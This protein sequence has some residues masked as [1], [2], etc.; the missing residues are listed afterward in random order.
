MSQ[1][2]WKITKL[3]DLLGAVIIGFFI[4]MLAKCSV[5]TVGLFT[6]SDY[7]IAY[8]TK[9]YSGAKGERRIK[10]YYLVNGRIYTSGAERGGQILPTSR[11]VVRYGKFAPSGNKFLEDIPIPD[12]IRQ[13]TGRVWREFLRLHQL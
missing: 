5:E 11:Y 7:A 9:A 6:N 3:S 10:Y 2:K 4:V 12:S 1:N 13:D 8:V